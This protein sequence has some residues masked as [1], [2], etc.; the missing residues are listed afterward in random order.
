MHGHVPISHEEHSSSFRALEV[1]PSMVNENRVCSMT[2][3]SSSPFF[4]KPHRH[5]HHPSH[6]RRRSTLR[7]FGR[8]S[9][10]WAWPRSWT[11][12]CPPPL[13]NDALVSFPPTYRMFPMMSSSTPTFSLP[14]PFNITS[15]QA[16]LVFLGARPRGRLSGRGVADKYPTVGYVEGHP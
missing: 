7:A 3:S 13:A 15:S 14:T 11:I 8:G 16:G 1:T 5:L 6:C 2:L 10:S 12:Q 4:S 9:C